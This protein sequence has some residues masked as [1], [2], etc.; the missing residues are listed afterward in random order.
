MFSIFKGPKR[1]ITPPGSSRELPKET[2]KATKIVRNWFGLYTTEDPRYYYNKAIKYYKIQKYKL[3]L[4]LFIKAM[5][6]QEEALGKEHEQTINTYYHIAK[7]YFNTKDYVKAL[8]YFNKV[9]KTDKLPLKRGS[10]HQFIAV[11]YRDTGSYAK[12]R[13][14]FSRKLEIQEAAKEMHIDY[15]ISNTYYDIALVCHQQKSYNKAL[16]NC[17]KAL[18]KLKGISAERLPYIAKVYLTIAQSYHSQQ[19]FSEAL[20]YSH[21]ALSIQEN[22]LEEDGLDLA[23]IYEQIASNHYA[24]EEHEKALNYYY[25]ALLDIQQNTPTISNSLP[26]AKTYLCI[27][28]TYF[29]QDKFNQALENYYKCLNIQKRLLEKN[30]PNIDIASTYEKIANSYYK[31]RKY[32]KAVKDY[33]TSLKMQQNL[34]TPSAL[35]VKARIL[36]SLAD[37]FHIRKDYNQALKYYKKSLDIQKY[38]LKKNDPDIIH[39]REQ[40]ATDIGYI[41]RMIANTYKSLASPYYGLEKYDKSLI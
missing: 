32:K 15:K 35:L 2:L 16:D 20:D 26:A 36:S 10:L 17:N 28:N 9:E 39:V 33:L 7:T 40:I 14:H 4:P 19:K 1:A 27:G 13:E 29:S 34:T 41:H 12:A 37:I 24:L 3:A 6:I 21:K 11:A 31:L 30:S 23:N 38:L 5:E 22:L 25:C 8:D 18:H